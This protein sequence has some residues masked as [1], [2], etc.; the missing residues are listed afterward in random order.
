[1]YTMRFLPAYLHVFSTS[2]GDYNV[3][4]IQIR[5]NYNKDHYQYLMPDNPR[6]GKPVFDFKKLTKVDDCKLP[7]GMVE[8]KIFKHIL[9]FEEIYGK[10]KTSHFAL[11]LYEFFT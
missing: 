4:A 3:L 11:L 1:M 6:V 2:E 9:I 5:S 10:L 7:F 8:V